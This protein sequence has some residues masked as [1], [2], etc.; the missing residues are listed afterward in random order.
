MNDL[1]LDHASFGPLGFGGAAI[2]NLYSSAVSEEV[3]HA[4]IRTAVQFG[5]RYFDT[6]QDIL[7]W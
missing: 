2:G 1:T 6:A 7:K 3:A 5:I 4:A